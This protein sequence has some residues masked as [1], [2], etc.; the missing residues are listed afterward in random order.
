VLSTRL[1]GAA[2]EAGRFHAAVATEAAVDGP[3]VE[4]PAVLLSGGETTVT[5]RGDG[6]G[7]PNMEFV[8]ACRIDLPEPAVV[9]AVDTDGRDGGT[10]AAGAVTGRIDDA[11][12][13]RRAVADNDTLPY[14]ASR[15]ALIET[16]STGTNVNDL[17]IVV[18]EPE[19]F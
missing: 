15:D 6:D 9:A 10:G 13:A 18:L 5:V 7:G 14:L 12:A 3:P 1:V 16:G 4:P 19:R 11:D 17:R 2:S 8:V